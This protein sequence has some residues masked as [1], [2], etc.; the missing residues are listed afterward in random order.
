[1]DEQ[2]M[3]LLN[4]TFTL[5]AVLIVGVLFFFVGQ[6]LLQQKSLD[7]QN[8]YQ[9][10]VSGE[11]KVYAKPDVALVSLGVTSQATTV[12]DVTKSTFKLKLL[13]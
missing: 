3:K 9:I 6:M 1:M 11:G 10:T 2:I 5:A 7:Q 4:K 8:N 13:L 12:A